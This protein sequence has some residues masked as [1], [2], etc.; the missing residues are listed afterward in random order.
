MYESASTPP[1]ARA[2]A[3][4]AGL[5]RRLLQEHVSD[6]TGRC[7]R[8]RWQTRAAEHWPCRVNLLAA[9]AQRCHAE[10]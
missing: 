4:M 1:A 7:V 6:G 8:C 9:A 2:L 3:P 10:R 5:W